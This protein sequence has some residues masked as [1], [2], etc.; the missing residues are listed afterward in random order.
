MALGADR[1]DILKLI[2]WDGLGLSAAG[3]ALGVVL[4]GI[5]IRAVSR[6]VIALPAIDA[7]TF[8]LVPLLIAGV[9]FLA[10]YLPALRAARVEPMVVLRGL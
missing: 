5:T 9:V 4:T 3:I 8:T 7:S 6:W 1:R 10:C 2:V